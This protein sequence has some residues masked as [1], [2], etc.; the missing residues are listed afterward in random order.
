M[1]EGESG[2]EGDGGLRE[3]DNETTRNGASKAVVVVRGQTDGAQ[4]A[5]PASRQ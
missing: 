5:S 1:A 4:P 3:P 2:G